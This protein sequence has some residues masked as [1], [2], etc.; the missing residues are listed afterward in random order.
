MFAKIMQASVFPRIPRTIIVVLTALALASLACRFGSAE[1]P[2]L[3]QTDIAIGIQ[4]TLIAQTAA[5]LQV[6]LSEATATSLAPEA[7][8]TLPPSP[9]PTEAATQPVIPTNTLEPSS[10]PTTLA[11]LSLQ[12]TDWKYV[13]F[14]PVS[15]GC[16]LDDVPCWLLK[17]SG[18]GMWKSTA[19]TEGT[20]TTAS[21]AY[22]D[23]AWANPALIYWHNF[24]TKG[25]GYRVSLQIDGRWSDVRRSDTPTSGWV[26]EV[27]D[28]KSY[29]GSE[30]NIN[31]SSTVVVAFVTPNLSV[32]WYIQDV[33]IVPDY[34]PN[35]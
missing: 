8:A 12:L 32:T 33:Q 6:G 9:E 23:P 14:I 22:I 26:Q 4:Q 35:P 5:A 10:T 7:T 29:K 13:A 31:F 27:I 15:S 25:F 2:S 16:K 17:L 11:P 21:P 3:R 19:P 18:S 28:L 1:D 20:M 24:Q 34:I 30:I